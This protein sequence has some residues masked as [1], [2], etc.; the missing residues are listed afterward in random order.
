[1]SRWIGE[2]AENRHMMK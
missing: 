2:F 1:M